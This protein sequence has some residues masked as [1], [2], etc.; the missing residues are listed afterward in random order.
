MNMNP[1]AQQRRPLHI[2]DLG[3]A[4]TVPEVARFLNTHPSTVYRYLYDG[5]L[6][7]IK[8]F[9]RARVCTKSIDQFLARTG[10]YE[11]KPSKL[12]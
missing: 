8:G 3:P 10:Q 2:S 11:V 4:P 6:K 9:G 1:I 5:A 7:V 12:P